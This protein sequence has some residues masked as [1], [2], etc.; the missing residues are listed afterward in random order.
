MRI[1]ETRERLFISDFSIWMTAP[2]TRKILKS[3][4]LVPTFVCFLRKRYHKAEA[5]RHWVPVDSSTIFLINSFTQTCQK[6]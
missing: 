2:L 6:A 4:I 1:L 5:A 3:N